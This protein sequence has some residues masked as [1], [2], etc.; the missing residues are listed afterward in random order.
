VIG[1]A[2]LTRIRA[3]RIW[4]VRPPQG[5]RGQQPF[6]GARRRGLWASACRRTVCRCRRFHTVSMR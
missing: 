3:R 4:P 1:H 5:G 2:I 6:S